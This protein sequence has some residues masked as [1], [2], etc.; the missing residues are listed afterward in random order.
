MKALQKHCTFNHDVYGWFI[1]SI[2]HVQKF[3]MFM[4]EKWP[5]IQAFALEGIGAG[6]FFTMKYKVLYLYSM[7]FTWFMGNIHI[8]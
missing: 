6:V 1:L 7:T 3:D 8:L 5:I 4:L 2:G